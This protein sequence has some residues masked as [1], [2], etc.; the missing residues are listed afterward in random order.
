MIR[1]TWGVQLITDMLLLSFLVEMVLMGLVLYTVGLRF[2]AVT[3]IPHRSRR[4]NDIKCDNK[5]TVIN[6]L[7]VLFGSAKKIAQT[8]CEYVSSILLY[9]CCIL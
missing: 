9:V 4:S 6:D 2:A 1:D 8:Y 3:G 7:L 5:T